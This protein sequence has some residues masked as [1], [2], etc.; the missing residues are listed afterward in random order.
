MK[1]FLKQA[2]IVGD[3]MKEKLV[4]AFNIVKS[5]NPNM[6]LDELLYATY[7]MVN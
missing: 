4:N 6:S 2:N 1:L 3:Y 5:N 7:D